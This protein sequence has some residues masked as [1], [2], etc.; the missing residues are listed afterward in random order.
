MMINRG[1]TQKKQPGG[2]QYANRCQED[3]NIQLSSELRVLQEDVRRLIEEMES[4]NAQLRRKLKHTEAERQAAMIARQEDAERWRK[5]RERLV[6]DVLQGMGKDRPFILDMLEVIGEPTSTLTPRS[7]LAELKRWVHEVSGE[8]LSRFP[9]EEYIALTHAELAD[10]DRGFHVG[11]ERPFT[12]G[13]ERVTFRVL[14][15]GWRLGAYVLHPARL[16]AFGVEI[17][18]EK[19]GEV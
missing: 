10:P 19:E 4:E 13:Q 12:D 16:S 5:E 3:G 11:N 18:L 2:E 15:Q 7:V 1:K 8:R 17:D 14:R 9:S 6:L